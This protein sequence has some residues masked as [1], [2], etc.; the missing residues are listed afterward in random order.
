M[1]KCHFRER[2]EVFKQ[3]NKATRA[4]FWKVLL[5]TNCRMWNA[6]NA[7]DEPLQGRLARAEPATRGVL[8]RCRIGGLAVAP[9]PA[10]LG[11]CWESAAPSLGTGSPEEELSWG[12]GIF[13]ALRHPA[14]TQIWRSALTPVGGWTAPPHPL[15]GDQGPDEGPLLPGLTTL[16]PCSALSPQ[17]PAGAGRDSTSPSTCCLPWRSWPARSPSWRSAR[18][19]SRPSTSSL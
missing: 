8:R 14:H 19:P 18:G 2:Q 15:N 5:A 6:P 12:Y 17:P 16:S 3:E 9:S 4:D 11:G 1:L 10:Y 7:G 13:L